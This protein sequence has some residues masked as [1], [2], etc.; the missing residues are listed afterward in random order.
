MFVDFGGQQ[1]TDHP[2]FNQ[3]RGRLSEFRHAAQ[4]SV[5]NGD[6]Q[7][8]SVL[9]VYLHAMDLLDQLD[10]CFS[11]TSTHVQRFEIG[12]FADKI[13]PYGKFFFFKHVKVR[14]L[15]K[16]WSKLPLKLV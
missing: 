10:H 14:I 15:R 11:S 3:R 12:L 4:I 8:E 6:S 13:I 16:F 7:I 5:R 9:R 1:N 2:Q